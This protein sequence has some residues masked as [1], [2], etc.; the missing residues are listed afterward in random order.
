VTLLSLLR[1]CFDLLT[2]LVT[3]YALICT[4]DTVS[5][6]LLTVLTHLSVTAIDFYILVC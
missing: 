1:I 4:P 5:L 3:V 6:T 2:V